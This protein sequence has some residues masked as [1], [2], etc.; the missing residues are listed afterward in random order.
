MNAHASRAGGPPAADSD[1]IVSLVAYSFWLARGA[2]TGD[3]TMPGRGYP[4][5]A[6]T[7]DG[8]DPERGATVYAAKCA[9]C[10]GA[11]GAGV[12]DSEGRTLF[13]PLWG[14]RSYNWGA[15]MH[16]IDT[17]VA[18]VKHNMPLGLAESL[19]DQ[20]AWDV[21]AFMNSHERPQDPRYTGDLAAT[22]AQFHASK[23]DYYNRKSPDGYL[24]GERLLAAG[25]DQQALRSRLERHVLGGWQHA[26]RLPRE[27]QL[28]RMRG[29][30]RQRLEWKLG[31]EHVPKGAQQHPAFRLMRGLNRD[32]SAWRLVSLSRTNDAAAAMHA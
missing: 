6:D 14:A 28:E 24:L 13:P 12:T 20:E 31:V 21:A 8:F 4:R 2:P 3:A 10:H 7:A 27:P 16:R 23:F 19:S 30:A 29:N 26:Q 32:G 11:D 5:L 22:A 15:G 9:L 18:F 17:A 25:A 1:T